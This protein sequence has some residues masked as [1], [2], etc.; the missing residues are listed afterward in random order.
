MAKRDVLEKYN[1]KKRGWLHDAIFFV[2]ALI[3]AIILL[4]YFVGVSF[5]SGDSMELN[6]KDGDCVIYLRQA[7]TFERGDI[8]SVW[9]PSGNYYVKRVVAVEDDT[10]DIHDGKIYI[11]GEELEETYTIGQTDKQLRAV[12][13]PYTVREG[14]IF[15]LGDNRENSMDS[16]TFGEVSRIQIRGKII[17][18]ISSHGIVKM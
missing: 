3:I 10:V 15:V 4:R 6:L 7:S 1:S 14:N 8:V 18:K 11:N 16:R 12:V 5:V 17:Y 13:Y 9:V 2:V